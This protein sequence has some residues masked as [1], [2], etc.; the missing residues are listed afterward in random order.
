MEL[1]GDHA[2]DDAAYDKNSINITWQYCDFREQNNIF[3]LITT[4]FLAVL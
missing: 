4:Y 1:K 2:S 3:F